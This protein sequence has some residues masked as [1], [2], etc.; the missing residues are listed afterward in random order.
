MPCPKQKYR[1]I[2]WSISNCDIACV[3]SVLRERYEFYKKIQNTELA[4]ETGVGFDYTTSSFRPEI[5]LDILQ[6]V[7]FS[8]KFC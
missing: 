8:E 7:L 1:I 4:E 6:Y 5:F 2:I 3:M